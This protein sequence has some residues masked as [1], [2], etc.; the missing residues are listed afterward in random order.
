MYKH[1]ICHSNFQAALFAWLALRQEG[2]MRATQVA[3]LTAFFGAAAPR[4]TRRAA[5]NL[6]ISA[7]VAAAALLGAGPT[8]AQLGPTAAAPGMGATS[9]LGTDLTS[10]SG[11][12][13]GA[14]ELVPGGLSPAPIGPSASTTPC[15]VGSSGITGSATFD[16]GGINGTSD[17]SMAGITGVPGDCGSTPSSGAASGME[18]PPSVPGST[19]ESTLGGGNIP[20]GATELDSNS[21]GLSPTLPLQPPSVRSS[22]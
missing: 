10:P 7:L 20:L 16:G 17:G 21:G 12:P 3:R 2:R 9:P 22:P 5:S 8:F 11:I 6:G 18:S 1:S 19:T 13:L 14:T 15:S 4:G